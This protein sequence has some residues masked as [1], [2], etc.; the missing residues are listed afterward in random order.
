M[1]TEKIWKCDLCGDFV[2]PGDLRR[3]SVRTAEDRPESG[4]V[5]DVGPECHAR[6]ISEVLTLA[7]EHGKEFVR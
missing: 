2:S 1:A 4:D 7:A 3:L 6:P 5:I